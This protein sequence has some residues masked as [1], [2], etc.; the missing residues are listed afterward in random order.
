M[1]QSDYVHIKLSDVPPEFIEEYNIT[2]P[3]QNGWVY[4]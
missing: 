1:D 2:Q 3:V 4:F